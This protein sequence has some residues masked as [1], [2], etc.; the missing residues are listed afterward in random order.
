MSSLSTHTPV[1]PAAGAEIT[2][3]AEASTAVSSADLSFAEGLRYVT[4]Q[5]APVTPWEAGH[6]P[7]LAE[8]REHFGP[9][10]D[11]IALGASER[12]AHRVLPFVEIAELNRTGFTVL[13]VP[14]EYGGPGVPFS[15]W[16]QL[17][18]DLAAADPNIA[19][20]YRSHAGFVETLRYHDE[21][22]REFWYAKVLAGDVVGNASTEVSGNALNTLN[23]TLAVQA[24][25]SGVLNGAKYYCT[26]TAYATHTRVSATLLDADGTPTEGRQFAVVSTRAPGVELEDDWNGFGQSL[27]GTGTTRFT[28]VKV[29]PEHILNR[30]PGSAEA[31]FEAPLFQIVLLAVLAGIARNV[32]NDAAAGVRRRTR[33]FN[34]GLGVPH[35]E[36]PQILGVVG[37]LSAQAFVVES[38]VV[39]AARRLE[40]AEGVLSLEEPDA[41]R[42]LTEAELAV[43]RAH[44]T[45]PSIVTSICSDLFLTGGASNTSREKNLDRHW[46]NAQTVATHNPIVFRERIIGDYLVN[47]TLPEGLNAIGEVTRAS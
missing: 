35:S 3:D 7:S 26:G 31:Q 36:D 33:S 39:E 14:T 15:D 40:A 19:H 42:L 10:F 46:R 38:A 43:E 21:Q 22:T 34:T 32:V 45:V 6:T 18:I 5:D 25:G 13:R 17:L 24:D 8:L 12:E 41:Q 29:A 2:A 28:D 4:T 27:T 30:V 47:G 11:R 1:H 20:Q 23:T 16:V 44:V 9:I 37:R